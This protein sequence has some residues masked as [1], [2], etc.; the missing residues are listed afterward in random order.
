MA[1]L[2]AVSVAFVSAVAFTSQRKTNK[3]QSPPCARQRRKRRQ[4]DLP[5][6]CR[7][8]PGCA[9]TRAS[10]SPGTGGGTAA[11]GSGAPACRLGCS[12]QRQAGN[13]VGSSHFCSSGTRGSCGSVESNCL[14]KGIWLR[15]Q[16]I[17][18]VT[19]IALCKLYMP[20]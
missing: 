6:G 9:A 10:A 16:R 8:R 15:N 11:Q 2:P 18:T 3:R 20:I 7:R 5:S 1:H 4:N 12:A 17:T 14:I 13:C 19:I